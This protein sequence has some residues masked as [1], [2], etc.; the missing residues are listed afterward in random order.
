M[1]ANASGKTGLALELAK[2]TD[3]EVISA[4]S[5]QIY[6]HLSAGTSKPQGT[7]ET[8]RGREVY[9][10]DGVPYHLVDITDPKGAYDAGTFAAEAKALMDSISTTG[11]TPIIT[12][13]T[14][15]YIQ[16]LWNGLDQLPPADPELRR[17]FAAFAGEKGKEALH[18]ELA[19]LDPAAAARIPPGN[20]QRV[21][22]ALEIT[23]LAGRPASELWTGRFMNALPGHLGRFVF[24]KWEKEPLA[25]RIKSRTV[26]AF[27]AWAEE[28]RGLLARGY[29]EDTPAL[30]SLG[31]PQVMDFI[32]GRLT[33]AETIHS[34]VAVS[35]AYAKRQNTWFGRYKNAELITLSSPKDY[36]IERLAERILR[37][38]EGN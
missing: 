11:K 8:V 16:A 26:S 29:P 2:R 36:D 1:G 24:L 6:K 21:M 15:M 17:S 27:D 34:I 25:E 23:K 31:Y 18:A 13:G 3:G 32:A 20:I 4:D 33:R 9:L 30:K 28:T 12:G 7:W 35:M 22:R 38:G 14:G 10:V 5:K 19:A 37:A